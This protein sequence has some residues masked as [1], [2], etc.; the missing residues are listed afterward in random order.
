MGHGQPNINMDKVRLRTKGTFN[1]QGNTKICV[2]WIAAAL[3][4]KDR[5][6][7]IGQ[8]ALIRSLKLHAFKLA[9]LIKIF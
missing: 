9:S 4:L 2:S 1:K 7:R 5:K 8:A 6:S 3:T